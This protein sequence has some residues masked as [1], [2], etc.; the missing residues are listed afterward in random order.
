MIEKTSNYSLKLNNLA[1]GCKQ[2]VLGRKLVVFVTGVCPKNCFYCP[3]SEHKKNT[4]VI[5]ANERKLLDENDVKAMIDEAKACKAYGAGFTGGDPLMRI[6]R[7]CRYIKLLKKEFG[8]KF[9]IHLYTILETLDEKKIKMLEDAG[10]DELR[11]H[12]DLLK[13][14]SWEKI[15]LIT[16]RKFKLGVEIPLIPGYDKNTLELVDYFVP[17]INFINLNELEISDTNSCELQ[18]R[19]FVTKDKRSYA[20]KGSAELGR[21]ILKHINEKYPKANV[22]FCTSKLK[23]KVQL[24][25]RL[26]LRAKNTA[27]EYD[28]VNPDGTLTRGVIYLEEL[29]PEFGYRKKLEKIS[30][31]DN[32]RFLNI[33]KKTREDIISELG[34]PEKFIDV[35]EKKLRLVSNVGIVQN[36]SKYLKSRKLIPAIVEQY[37]TWDQMEVDIEFL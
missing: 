28:I 12:P 1:D 35:D 24:R 2:C 11:V 18:D 37:P 3:L 7:T 26:I 17:Q 6:E 20:V 31:A 16:N 25:N 32:I 10:L 9:H 22:H 27:K 14:D 23:D 15:S 4:D 30:A 13:K 29:K 21:K 36:I 34:I 33:L 8:K 5:Y 19:D